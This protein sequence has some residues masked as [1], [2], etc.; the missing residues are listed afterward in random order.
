MRSPLSSPTSA[1]D[2]RA[3]ITCTNRANPRVRARMEGRGA[4]S[5][6]SAPSTRTEGLNQEL[7]S[8]EACAR[9]RQGARD[10]EQGSARPVHL[11]R[12]RREDALLEHRGCAGRPRPSQGGAR[13]SHPRRP[14]RR[15]GQARQGIQVRQGGRGSRGHASPCRHASSGSCRGGAG[16]RRTCSRSRSSCPCAQ[17]R[18]TCRA[19]GR[20][21]GAR[22][23]AR[24]VQRV[25]A[26]AG[27]SPSARRGAASRPGPG[28]PTGSRPWPR[29]GATAAARASASPPGGVAPRTA[30]GSSGFGLGAPRPGH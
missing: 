1:P 7:G 23:P 9:A 14:A 15:A 6:R 10:D 13:G 8:E 25:R 21:P 18:R 28:G 17:A 30:A 20:R 27:P 2:R 5:C 16:C 26:T 19:T 29:R 22:R 24:H 11:A 3:H 12:D 4:A